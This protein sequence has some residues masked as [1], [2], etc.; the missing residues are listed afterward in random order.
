MQTATERPR[1]AP[2]P[3]PLKQWL[4]ATEAGAL[5]GINP[6]SVPGLAERGLITRRAIPGTMPRYYRPDVERLART[7]T[8]EAAAA[9]SV[10]AVGA[11]IEQCG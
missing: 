9:G 6:R 5:L 1:P 8:T 2:R 10:E 3:R 4:F 7:W 11:D